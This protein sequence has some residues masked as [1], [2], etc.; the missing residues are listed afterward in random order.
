MD[1]SFPQ[2]LSINRY[3]LS[4]KKNKKRLQCEL[5][6]NKS[7]F[8]KKVLSYGKEKLKKRFK[9]ACLSQ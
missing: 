3:D 2:T 6:S 9:L 4:M 1:G 5:F 7:K 8:R